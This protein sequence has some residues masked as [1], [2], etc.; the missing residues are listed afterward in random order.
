MIAGTI[1]VA[2]LECNFD[3]NNNY[4]LNL[5]FAKLG[6]DIVDFKPDGRYA[7]LVD[8]KTKKGVE[9]VRGMGIQKGC[10]GI[11]Q[12]LIKFLPDIYAK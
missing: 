8:V 3:G 1:L 11:R 2:H 6:Q 9:W 7:P 10:D 5:A 12:T 4:P